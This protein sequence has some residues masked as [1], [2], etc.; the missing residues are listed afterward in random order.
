MVSTR[1]TGLTIEENNQDMGSH[2][3]DD[4]AGVIPAQV[5]TFA[6]DG[7]LDEDRMAICTRFLMSRGVNGLYLTGSTGEGFM[8]SP[9]ERKR[10]VEIVTNEVAGSIPVIVHVGAISTH[11]TVDLARHAQ[12]NGVD[13]LSSVPPIY[14]SFTP[15]QIVNYYADITASTD[16]PMIAYNVPL[17]GVLGFDMIARLAQ[18]DGMAGVKYTA[19]THH[20]IL[21]IK[22][23]IG[24][25]FK[26]YSGSDEMAMSGLAFGADGLIGSFYNIIPE[27]YLALYAA[28]REGRLADAKALQETANTVIFF[29]LKQYPMS[30]V[31]RIMAWQGADAGY[32]RKPFD[33][34]FTDAD[35]NALKDAYR[36]LRD[37]EKLSGVDFLEV[38]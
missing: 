27:I 28:M 11:Q 14:W 37:R 13:A 10:V 3:I 17:A 21:R 33:N 2:T 24:T 31:K 19:P 32:C 26:V 12:A 38:I 34:Y 20:E 16:L 7:A 30:A 8:M 23:E 6:A 4:I 1:S 9:D 18:I 5:T 22:Q 35:E 25:D 15:D 29:T 36:G